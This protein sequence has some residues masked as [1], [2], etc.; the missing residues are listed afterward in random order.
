[1][2]GAWMK[3]GDGQWKKTDTRWIDLWGPIAEIPVPAEYREPKAEKVQSSPAERIEKQAADM[4]T[5][6]KDAQ[7]KQPRVMREWMNR[8]AKGVR[9]RQL[10]DLSYEYLIDDKWLPYFGQV[11]ILPAPS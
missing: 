4:L 11:S 6:I 2:A 9:H 10:S 3:I 5:F 1:M 7:E 8:E